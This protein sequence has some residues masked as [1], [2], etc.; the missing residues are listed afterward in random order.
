MAK[1]FN[2]L[3]FFEINGGGGGGG[4]GGDQDLYL[5]FDQN[6]LKRMVS[7]HPL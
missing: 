4:G 3:C 7:H 5:F 2:Y 1:A 6:L